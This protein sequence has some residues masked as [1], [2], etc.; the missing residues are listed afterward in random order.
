MGDKLLTINQT[1]KH[2]GISR[3]TLFRWVADGRLQKV[4]IGRVVRFRAD[5]CETLVRK[6][7]TGG[8]AK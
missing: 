5:D 8:R 7:L 4:A 3:R 1:V 6:G 2:F